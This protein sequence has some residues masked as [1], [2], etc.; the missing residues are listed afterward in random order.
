MK[1]KFFNGKIENQMIYVGKLILQGLKKLEASKIRETSNTYIQ[2]PNRCALSLALEGSPLAEYMI[3][4]I[5]INGFVTCRK[6]AHVLE[7]HPKLAA[8]ISL[9][10]IA[11]E[12]ADELAEKLITGRM[13]IRQFH[14]KRDLLRFGEDLRGFIEYIDLK[15]VHFYTAFNY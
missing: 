11:G 7:I 13:K 12:T 2:G 4:K 3:W 5:K 14:F 8:E 1:C 10:H 6:L 9:R 15:P